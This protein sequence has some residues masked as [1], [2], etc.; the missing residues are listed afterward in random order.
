MAKVEKLIKKFRIVFDDQNYYEAHQVA[1][2]IFYRWLESAEY[3]KL[4]GFLYECI[5]SFVNG[6]LKK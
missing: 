1:R 2:T 4:S 6:K 3:E 5:L